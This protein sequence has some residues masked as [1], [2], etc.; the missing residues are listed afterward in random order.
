MRRFVTTTSCRRRI[1]LAYFGED[2]EEHEGYT[3]DKCGFCDNCCGVTTRTA[4]PVKSSQN[5]QTEAKLLIELIESISNRSFGMGMYINIL[6][7]SANKTVTSILRKSKF[8]GKGKH[9]SVDW[10]KE[11]VE[12]LV[13][14]GYLQQI[15]LKGGRF[16][17]QVLKVTQQGVTWA[18]MADLGDL[19]DDTVLVKKLEPIMMTVSA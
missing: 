9:R 5:V 10:W 3:A 4:A 18:N 19:L 14:L 8:Y 15:Y 16:P 7:G 13:T 12:N 1:L 11:L 2:L 17:M 6:R